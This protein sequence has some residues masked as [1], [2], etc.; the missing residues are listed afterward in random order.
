MGNSQEP[1]D[2][3]ISVMPSSLTP[4]HVA[5]AAEGLNLYD[6]ASHQVSHF[7]PL[8]PGEV[9]I[10]VC[11]ATVQSSPHIGHIRAAVA[12]D[13]VRRW[14]LK[15]GYKVTFVRNVTD[16]D[17]KILDK[18][19]AAGQRW[20]ARAYYYEREFTE[21]YNTLGVL[22]PTVEPRAT[23]H[24]SD[25][26]DL[27]QRILDNGHGYVVTDADGKPTG[28]VYFDVA[29]WPHYGELTHQK[30]TSEVDEAAAVADRMGPSVDATGADKYNPV[31]PAD[32]SPDKHD[33]RDFALWKAPKD[34]DPEDARWSTPFGVG[35]PGWHIECSAMSH[36]YLADG[37]DIHG[38]G[39]DLRFPHHENEMAQTR[40]AGFP[41]AARWMHSAW[42]TAKGEKMSKSLGTGLSV[43]SVLAEHS[44][45]VVRYALGSVQYRSMLEWSDQALVEAQAAY[46]RVSNFIERAGVALGDLKPNRDEITAVPADDLPADFV[47][48]MND[49]VNVSGA[50]AAIFTAIRSGNT[51]LSQLADRADSE[52]AKAEVREA[53][54]A[55]RAMLDTLG[56]DPLAEPWVSAGVAGGAADGTAESPEHA[57]LEALIA[58]QLNARAE[59]RKAK[60]F[61]KADQIRDALTEAGIAIEDGPQGSIWS[62][63]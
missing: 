57:A 32:A 49:D 34:T 12:F 31:D 27:I 6:T 21:A 61:A 10:Y 18:A 36:R 47:A 44:A 28:N 53:L 48:A 3:N 26:I 24:M 17:D 16:I 41:S 38:G 29:S 33:P 54:L 4:V 15:L 43:P 35:R 63:K 37:F 23:G 62:L 50:T 59:A 2:F 51:L 58:E 40:A 20:W 56:L 19:A 45:W 39:L 14:F 52:T 5:K 7:V 46:D 55:V 11:G 13:I 60:D 1:Q 42:V 22:P 30:Q 8:K 9:G 25:M